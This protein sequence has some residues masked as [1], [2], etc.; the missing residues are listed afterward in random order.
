V[1]RANW[2]ELER[3]LEAGTYGNAE[4]DVAGVPRSVPAYRLEDGLVWGLTERI[5]S[6]LFREMGG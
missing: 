1:A 5:L 4:L 3:L 6:S 2:V